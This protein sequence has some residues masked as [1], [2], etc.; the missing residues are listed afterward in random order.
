MDLLSDDANCGSCGIACGNDATCS[1]G[2]CVANPT[3]SY[4]AD[5][6]PIWNAT[7][8]GCHTSSSPTYP[9][10]SSS[11]SY[12]NLVD[13]SSFCGSQTLVIPG[14]PD[15]SYLYKKLVGTHECG[16]LMPRNRP[17]LSNSD[18]QTVRS[19]ISEGALNN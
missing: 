19:W 17:A 7:C 16:S 12:D 10:L 8:G 11:V 18:V 14:N 9:G 13:Q 3:V 2:S 1:E 15:D 4:A 5:V 6:Q